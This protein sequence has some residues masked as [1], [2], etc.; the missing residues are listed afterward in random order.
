MTDDIED[1]DDEP[2]PDEQAAHDPKADEL[3]T[4][5]ESPEQSDPAINPQGDDDQ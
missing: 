2:T 5:D 3:A 4:A 1:R